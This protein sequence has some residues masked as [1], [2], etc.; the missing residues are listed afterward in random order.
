[1]PSSAKQPPEPLRFVDIL[2]T[3]S[4]IAGA[5]NTPQLGADEIALAVRVVSGAIDIEDIGGAVHPLLIR[6][7]VSRPVVPAVR[8]LVQRWYAAA[9]GTA[10]S[11][12]S[13]ADAERFVTELEALPTLD[14]GDGPG[15]E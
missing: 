5:R 2:T 14:G 11:L 12:L 13:Q 4:S 6:G 8:E 3:A 1:V 7:N 15:L 9:G 10:E